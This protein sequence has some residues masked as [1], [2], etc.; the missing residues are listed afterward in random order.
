MN[1]SKRR[2]DD[3]PKRFTFIRKHRC[4]M[5]KNMLNKDK[6]NYVLKY[7]SAIAQWSRAFLAMQSLSFA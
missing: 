5:P 4:D 7:Y 6:K 1:N 2:L 3:F